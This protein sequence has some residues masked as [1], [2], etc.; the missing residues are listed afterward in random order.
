MVS[1]V[2]RLS[3]SRRFS[4]FIHVVAEVLPSFLWLSDI[5]LGAGPRLFIRSSV[6][7]HLHWFHLL[8]M[9][10]HAGL[11]IGVHV[12]VGVPVSRSLDLSSGMELLGHVITMFLTF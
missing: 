11:N 4:G 12:P 7:G 2:W 3:L 9:V 5:P 10:N 8:A 6:V 1:R